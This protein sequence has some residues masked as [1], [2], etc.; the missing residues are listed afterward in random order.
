M[1]TNRCVDP[2]EISSTSP[3]AVMRCWMLYGPPCVE[4]GATSR[5][6]RCLEMEDIDMSLN[7]ILEPETSTVGL[8]PRADRDLDLLEALRLHEPTAAERLVTTYG[9]RAYRLA[10][11]I[12]GNEQDAEEVVQDA[13]W[14][15]VRKI[16]TFRGESAFGSWLYRIVANAAYQKLR[17]WRSRGRDLSLDEVLPSFDAHGR[18]VGPVA[19]WSARVDDPSVQTELRMALTAAI[20]ELHPVSRTMLVLRDV[21]GFSNSEIA[22]ALGLSV[23]IVKVRVH[24]ARLFLR[25]QLG[26]AMATLGDYQ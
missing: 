11:S 20:D 18:H 19:D 16:E 5:L 9:E 2:S 15:V 12:T 17:G 10:T 26:D 21:E 6:S 4:R 22:E 13:F 24:R 23:T 14:T 7:A 1:M 25:K 3:S 8:R